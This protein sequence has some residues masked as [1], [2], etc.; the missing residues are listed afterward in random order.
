MAESIEKPMFPLNR[1]VKDFFTQTLRQINVNLMT[2]RIFPYEVYP[3]YT[4][5]NNAN[6]RAG[7]P[8]ST[9]RG[10]KSFKGRI[11]RSDEAGNVTLVFAYNDYMQYVDIGVGAGRSS[12][13]VERSKNAKFRSRY[14]SVWEPE[15]GKTHRPAIMMEF[16]H[17][18]TRIRDY[19]ADFYGYKG[20]VTLAHA[21]GEGLKIDLGTY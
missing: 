5:K 14:V 12:G 18:Q 21:F 2:Q 20:R 4:A 17:L 16:R 8:H 10:A 15:G 1:V 11:A 19:L 6:K 7:L 3:G 13:K 9:G